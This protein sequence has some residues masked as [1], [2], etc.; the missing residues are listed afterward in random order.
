MPNGYVC[1]TFDFDALSVWVDR[2]Q[3]SATPRSR[4]EF[5]AVAVPRLLDLLS[6]RGLPATWFVPGHTARTY[7]DLCRRIRDRGHEIA[8]HGYAHENVAAL[9]ED[10]E[11]TVLD[12]S[13]E[14]LREAAGVEPLGFRAPAWD[15]SENTV[16]L[17]NERGLRY[18]SSL[19]GHDYAPYRCRTG[20]RVDAESARWGE[21]TP[22]VEVPVSWTL[23][24]L[25][26]LEFLSSPARTLP[27]LGDAE[28]MFVDW[29]LD[30][31][32][33]LRETEQGVLT[34]TCHPQVIGRGHRLLRL[35]EWLDRITAYGV[36][37]ATVGAVADLAA[38]GVQLGR[39]KAAPAE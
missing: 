26:H 5:G 23:D 10:A 39:P 12:R 18:D 7:P 37:F 21:E 8:L 29:E 22:L 17:L 4:G 14:A 30:L 3:L 11:R 25:P 38:G 13:V 9:D 28:R 35:E 36:E 24:D 27:G 16:A 2:G 6:R 20:D 1:L 31:R 33:M 19:M 34:V 15:L 32:Y